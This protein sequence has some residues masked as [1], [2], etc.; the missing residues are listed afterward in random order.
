M[1]H[2]GTH[3]G[4]GGVVSFTAADL[5]VVVV[6]VSGRSN[7]PVLPVLVPDSRSWVT[8]G[9]TYR[10][11]VLGSWSW[12]TGGDRRDYVHVA[13]MTIPPG[14]GVSDL[15]YSYSGGSSFDDDATA[16]VYRGPVGVQ[17]VAE[18]SGYTTSPSFPGLDDARGS[19]DIVRVVMAAGAG[20]S[21]VLPAAHTVRFSTSRGVAAGDWVGQ[22]G[23][24]AGASAGSAPGRAWGTF[25]L[26]LGG[27]RVPAPVLSAPSTAD[28]S[29]AVLISWEPIPGQTARSVRRRVGAGA[30]QY[31]TSGGTWSGSVTWLTSSSS[32]IDLPG[33]VNGTTYQVAVAARVGVDES[34]WSSSR[35]IACRVA[36]PAPST[37]TISST[38]VRRP[39]ISASGAAG[40]GNTIT[41]YAISIV[42]GGVVV[43]SGVA[44]PGGTW[45]PAALPDGLVTIEARTMVQ[46]G[47]TGPPATLDVTISV[48]PVPAPVV[49]AVPVTHPASG[50]PGVRLMIAAPG[51]WGLEVIPEDGDLLV[52]TMI[53]ATTVDD[54]DPRP[55]YRVRI[56]DEDADPPESS[57]WLTIDA[58]AGSGEALTVQQ[59][60]Q[61]Q[62]LL[63]PQRPELALLLRAREDGGE[64]WDMAADRTRYR[65]AAADAVTYR[66]RVAHL[67][68]T[69]VLWLDGRADYD[70]L[71]AL[72]ALQA[73]L[74]YRWPP[75]TDGTPGRVD[76]ML[77]TEAA[78]PRLDPG[79]NHDIWPATLTWGPA[80][81]HSQ[82]EDDP[83]L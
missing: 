47:L 31:L 72:L 13:A 21:A 29:L 4:G 15:T 41:G 8:G 28:G 39:Q 75:S 52:G 11:V 64:T 17:A 71:V 5:D 10:W 12:A 22:T 53:D 44:P 14:F 79:I 73:P 9:K 67:G 78:L 43:D 83:W 48:P 36:P 35:T 56:I 60:A 49:A 63:D 57:V 24:V 3:S 42:V 45:K 54:Y 80:E 16:L 50:L 2:V 46:G 55:S 32:T 30:W 38:T 65:G 82:M 70:G 27:A 34:D 40:S 81:T 58:L 76:R 33:M 23:P 7:T 19:G 59:D 69:T 51:S 61:A 37:I 68:G 1:S 66:D 20:L 18:L 26:F 25:T 6:V 77:V 62:W 74:M